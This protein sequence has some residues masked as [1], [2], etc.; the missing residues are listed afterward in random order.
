MIS[1]ALLGRRASKKTYRKVV[2]QPLN[3]ML[4]HE[5]VDAIAKWADKAKLFET[6]PQAKLSKLKFLS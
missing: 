6:A 1:L 4:T 3:M 5:A 2:M